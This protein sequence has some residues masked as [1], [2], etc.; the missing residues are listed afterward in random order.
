MINSNWI[1]S[2]RVNNFDLQNHYDDA[3]TGDRKQ[4]L[5]QPVLDRPNTSSLENMPIGRLV[6]HYFGHFESV[7]VC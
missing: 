6:S 1:S 7:Y 2:L 4:M 5:T 3:S